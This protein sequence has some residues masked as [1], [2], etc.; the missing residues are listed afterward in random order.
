M[1]GSGDSSTLEG[2]AKPKRDWWDIAVLYLKEGS[3]TED[4]IRSHLHSKNIE[5][6][7]VFVFPSK[8][9][10]TVSA[11]V[12]VAL[13]HK[14]RALDAAIWPQNLRISSWTNQSKASRKNVA[15]NRPSAPESEL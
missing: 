9:K 8:I 7:E 14:D 15:G 2:V 13:A 4:K 1:S 11:K 12:R 6:K 5:V 10:G 3:T